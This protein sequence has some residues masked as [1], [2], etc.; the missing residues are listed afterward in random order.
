MKYLL[1]RRMWLTRMFVLSVS[2]I[3][4]RTFLISNLT[5]I[6]KELSATFKS[7]QN[8]HTFVQWKKRCSMVSSSFSQKS[9]KGEFTFLN[10]NSMLFVYKILFNILYWNSLNLV[11]SVV[12]KGSRYIFSQSNWDVCVLKASLYFFCAAGIL[13]ILEMKPSY[14]DLD[15]RLCK[16]TFFP[17]IH[18]MKSVSIR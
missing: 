14:N 16:L 8:I 15:L 17:S 4:N 10:L 6:F 11:S 13:D 9:H 2:K 1:S 18:K 5:A 12:L 3:P 7:F